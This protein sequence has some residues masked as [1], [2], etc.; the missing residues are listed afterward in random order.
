[1][2]GYTKD[3]VT[4]LEFVWG[5]GFLSPGGEE[6]IAALVG[7][8][9]LRGKRVLDFG[10]GLGG[11]DLLLAETYGAREVV[12]IDVAPEVV[13]LARTLAKRKGISDRVSFQ[14]A[15]PGALAFPDDAFDVVF[16]KDAMVHVAGKRALY[17][18]I[19]RVLKPGGSLIA[20]DWLWAPGA[21]D[22]PAVVEW[23]GNNPLGFV[24]TTV[25]E[26]RTAL[27]SA[28]FSDVE[29]RDRSEHIAERNRAEIARLEGPALTELAAKV[30]DAVA[31]DRLRSA[32][33]RQPVL[34]A[35][36]LLPTHLYGR[37]SQ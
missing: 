36:A 25:E 11:I 32:R 37:K 28:G 29:L 24:F 31:R 16:S 2:A 18:E 3:V 30:G 9:D 13:D 15:T 20:S 27:R 34:D 21:V 10:S 1:M 33:G 22:N 12:G 23:V 4:A 7:S 17:E 35:K 14:L 6:E 19:K 8:H 5:E 26:A